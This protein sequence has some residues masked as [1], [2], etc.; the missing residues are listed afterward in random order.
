MLDLALAIAHHLLIFALFGVL[1]AQLML[2]KPGVD[3]AGLR[4]ISRIDAAYGVAAVLVVVVGFAR[5]AFTAKGWDVYAHN[6]FFWAKVVTFALIGALSVP[7]TIF[8]LGARKAGEASPQG[9]LRIRRFLHAEAALFPL[10]PI[11]A[12]AMARGYG[13][14]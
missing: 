4:R 12:A 11:F 2:V 1:L 6:G 13:A 3:A 9:I 14:F 10:L 5:A 8:F 7:P